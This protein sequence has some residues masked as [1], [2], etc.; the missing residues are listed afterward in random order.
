VVPPDLRKGE[1]SHEKRA[2]PTL[3]GQSR[4]HARGNTQDKCLAQPHPCVRP[5]ETRLLEHCLEFVEVF[6][7]AQDGRCRAAVPEEIISHLF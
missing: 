4:A 3:S 7:I 2:V 5:Y 6:A 1:D